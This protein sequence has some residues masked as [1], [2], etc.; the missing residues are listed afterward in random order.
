MGDE[1]RGAPAACVHTELL[2]QRQVASDSE[3]RIKTAI[4]L[5]ASAALTRQNVDQKQKSRRGSVREGSALWTSVEALNTMPSRP[6]RLLRLHAGEMHIAAR[7]RPVEPGSP[8]FL[9]L[10]STLMLP[11]PAQPSPA[12]ASDACLQDALVGVSHLSQPAVSCGK[13][14]IA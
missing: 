1:Y 11:S 12:R 2:D 3:Y 10:T 9:P 6:E 8:F 5:Q 7:S 13:I 14:R 4:I